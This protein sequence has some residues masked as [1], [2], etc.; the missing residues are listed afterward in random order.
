MVECAR[1]CGNRTG[2]SRIGQPHPRRP[3][4]PARRP[5][6]QNMKAE[7]RTE[8]QNGPSVGKDE[9]PQSL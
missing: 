2:A 8:V 1:L 3:H 9:K 6:H 5:V 7:E 4:L